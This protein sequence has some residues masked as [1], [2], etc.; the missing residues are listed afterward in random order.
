MKCVPYNTILVPIF[1]VIYLAFEAPCC[2]PESHHA[3]QVRSITCDCT[4][5]AGGIEFYF[6]EKIK[7][8]LNI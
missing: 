1:K 5:A 8:I 6:H 3:D 2:G 7:Y 4:L